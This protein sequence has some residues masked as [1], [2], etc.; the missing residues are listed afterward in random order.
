MRP[1]IRF[2][3][4]GLMSAGLLA[5]C[6]GGDPP[7]TDR[8]ESDSS[9]GGDGGGGNGGGGNGGGGTTGRGISYVPLSVFESYRDFSGFDQDGMFR[10]DGEL[11]LITR[12][13]I[14]PVDASTLLPVSNAV[15]GDYK[16]TIDDVDIDASESF[17]VLQKVLGAKIGLRTALV[18]D[19]S[20]SVSHMDV[21]ALVAEAKAYVAAAQASSNE[22]IN[23]QEFVVW[24]F[25][26]LVEQ[27]TSGFTSDP[28]EINAALDLVAVRFNNQ[29]LL[30]TSSNLHQAIVRAIGRFDG[31]ENS[32]NYVFR[33][34]EV[35]D[36]DNF[37]NNDDANEND[38]LDL[39]EADEILLNH[40]VVFS[41]GPDTGLAFTADTMSKAIESQSL[42]K[43]DASS[44]GEM[45]KLKRPVFYY[46]MGLN[47]VGQ[48]YPAL[49]ALSERTTS[50]ILSGGAYSFSGNLITYQLAAIS[51]RVDVDNLYMYRY[52]FL[53][54][55][56]DH[57]A[58]FS[59]ASA[60]GFNYALTTEYN[61]DDIRLVPDVA[62][63]TEITGPNG[64][65]I[66][67]QELTVASAITLRPVTRWTSTAFGAGD[68]AWT[69]LAGAVDGAANGDGTYTVNA[70]TASP[71]VLQLTNTVISETYQIILEN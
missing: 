64:E 56:G 51:A 25:G 48:V 55:V 59:S 22:T 12:Y 53:P 7:I 36:P 71:A 39:V 43:Y 41:S 52:A 5:A 44:S 32:I 31:S 8:S 20:N 46:V 23:S 45:R 27:L 42:L 19:V 3:L 38:L 30:G 11:P 21:N 49:S 35:D 6:G 16:V 50:L 47:A 4:V 18:F 70:V 37:D 1:Y 60:T 15:V 68:Y 13:A 2:M 40:M 24:A 63:T 65:Y 33:D 62:P 28:A 61:D 9:S 67:N 14:S 69:V 29:T 66:S 54:R 26:T 10:G 58:V 57:T 17:P 34:G